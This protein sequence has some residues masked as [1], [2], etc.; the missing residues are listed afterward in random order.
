MTKDSYI[1]LN[2]RKIKEKGLEIYAHGGV[3]TKNEM[4]HSLST[5]RIRNLTKIRPAERFVGQIKNLLNFP[6]VTDFN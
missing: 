4:A 1:N 5:E 2:Q 3:P 6:T